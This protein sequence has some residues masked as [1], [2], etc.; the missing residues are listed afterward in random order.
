VTTGQT[1]CKTAK[2]TWKI[3]ST[4][5]YYFHAWHGHVRLMFLRN[6][7]PSSSGWESSQVIYADVDLS[8]SW[9][10]RGP[11]LVIHVDRCLT[12]TNSMLQ[13]EVSFSSEI[14]T[15]V[16]FKRCAEIFISYSSRFFFFFPQV[17]NKEKES[18]YSVVEINLFFCLLPLYNNVCW[19]SW[20]PKDL[21][22]RSALTMN[23][24]LYVTRQHK[25]CLWDNQLY[26]SPYSYIL[27]KM[28][29]AFLYTDCLQHLNSVGPVH[30]TQG[31]IMYY[32]HNIYIWSKLVLILAMNIFHLM[33]WWVNLM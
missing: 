3:W 19:V 11:H 8:D 16:M 31:H 9:M 10:R 26:I 20:D 29:W 4:K 6:V 28:R 1:I 22:A 17:C 30:N 27:H 12:L 23:S 7:S 15:Q 2:A 24:A 5:Y 18:G 32:R 21:V 25:H 13:M 14:S 33:M